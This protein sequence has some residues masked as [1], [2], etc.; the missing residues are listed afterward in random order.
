[1]RK[2]KN[3]SVRFHLKSC[4]MWK[5]NAHQTQYVALCCCGGAGPLGYIRFMRWLEN[6][7]WE[8]GVDTEKYKTF[9]SWSHDGVLDFR[10]DIRLIPHFRRHPKVYY[11]CSWLH[12]TK[13]RGRAQCRNRQKTSPLHCVL[14][15]SFKLSLCVRVCLLCH[16]GFTRAKTARTLPRSS[17]VNVFRFWFR[18]ES[19]Q[20]TFPSENISQTVSVTAAVDRH[21]VVR[22]KERR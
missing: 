9:R 2:K 15:F 21:I 16:Y 10:A 19:R 8:K 20:K 3:L 1:M 17:V 13:E 11:C 7:R 12:D 4:I 22:W 18:P 5:W 6:C 14:P